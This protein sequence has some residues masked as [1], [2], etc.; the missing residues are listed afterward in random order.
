MDLS[1][2]KIFIDVEFDLRVDILFPVRTNVA[3][4]DELVEKVDAVIP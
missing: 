2:L 4:S 1:T 3:E